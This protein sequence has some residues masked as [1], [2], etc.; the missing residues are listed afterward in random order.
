MSKIRTPAMEKL[1]KKVKKNA[2]VTSNT[3][4]REAIKRLRK[5]KTAMAG[6]I[7]M[8]SLSSAAATSEPSN[9]VYRG[10]FSTGHCTV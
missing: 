2:K 10:N 7:I 3:P 6:M 8:P 4:G 9:H 5:N 1:D